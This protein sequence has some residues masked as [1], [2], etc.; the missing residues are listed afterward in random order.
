MRLTVRDRALD[1]LTAIH[2]ELDDD[3]SALARLIV[4]GVHEACTG[5]VRPDGAGG[6]FYDLAK[7]D[8]YLSWRSWRR[9]I[10][11]ARGQR[12]RRLATAAMKVW[13]RSKQETD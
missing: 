8:V 1:A 6:Y 5:D 10:A 11:E 12:D 2:P 13:S 4:T 9:I 7:A 3:D